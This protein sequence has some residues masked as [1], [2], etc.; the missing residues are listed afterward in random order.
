MEPDVKIMNADVSEPSPVNHWNGPMRQTAE[1]CLRYK[2][3][4]LRAQA[5]QLDALAEV[6]NGLIP[7]SPEEEAMWLLIQSYKI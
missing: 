3:E 5:T 2:A 4:R 6:A 7:G 1:G